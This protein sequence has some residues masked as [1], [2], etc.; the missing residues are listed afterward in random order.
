MRLDRACFEEHIAARLFQDGVARGYWEMALR[1]G[2]EWPNV[3]I[4][5]DLP[6]RPNGHDK[7][8]LRFDLQDYPSR[9]PTAVPWDFERNVK[10]EPIKWPKGKG[11]V[12]IVFRTDWEGA[13]ALYAPWDRFAAERHDANWIKNYRGLEWNSSRTIVHYLRLTREVLHSDDYHGC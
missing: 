11:D 6:S 10:L 3:V 1:D 4:W 12:A 5:I 2:L 9:G 8:F 7:L 13:S